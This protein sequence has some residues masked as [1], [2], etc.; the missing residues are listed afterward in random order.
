MLR[1][2]LILFLILFNLRLYCQNN[3]SDANIEK[4]FHYLTIGEKQAAISEM[5][6]AHVAN[7][8]SREVRE[9]YIKVLSQADEDMEALRLWKDS[10]HLFPKLKD[11]FD[12]IETLAWSVLSKAQKSSQKNVKIASLYSSASSQNVKS[13]HFLE[14]ALSDPDAQLRM[15]AAKLSLNLRDTRL[16]D[17]MKRQLKREKVWYVRL[18]LLRSLAALK[19]KEAEKSLEVILENSK[20]TFE[21]KI[22]ALEGLVS[23]YENLEDINIS[24][25]IQSKRA[26]HRLLATRLFLA[27][28]YTPDENQA[29]CLLNDHNPDV[30]IS[31][32]FT[33]STLD[34]DFSKIRKEVFEL[35]KSSNVYLKMTANWFAALK[36]DKPSIQEL[37]ACCYHQ[38]SLERQLAAGFLSRLGP[39]AEAETLA[40]MKKT[41]DSYVK[42]NLA[43]GLIGLSENKKLLCKTIQSFLVECEEPIMWQSFFLHSFK[44]IMPS[45]VRHIPSVTNYPALIDSHTRLSLINILAIFRYDNFES[46]LK[47]YLKKNHLGATFYASKALLEEGT[48]EAISKIENLLE[49]P[50]IHISVQAALIL[51]FHGQDERAFSVLQTAYPQVNKGL[52][53]SILEALGQL[54]SKKNLDFLLDLLDDPFN[55]NRMLAASAIIQCVNH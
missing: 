47:E 11:N 46:S 53:S 55:V 39:I 20:A 9:A 37:V 18:E 27:L 48:S 26:G 5:R 38:N 33:L 10:S 16:I 8:T 25:F 45:Q 7:P 54:G 41:Q 30:I 22:I 14:N 52:K 28:N 40:V 2:A 4:A 34:Y 21:E 19:Q 42:V 15:L 23:I 24:S 43:Y 3:C 13:V 50:D 36:G 6:L 1:Y 32:L 44:L 17:A 49:D 35:K 12:L 51:A 31:T 29:K